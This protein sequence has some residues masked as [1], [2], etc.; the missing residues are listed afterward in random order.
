MALTELVMMPGEDYQAIC[1]AV[2]NKT[3]TTSLLCSGEVAP[4]IEAIVTEGTDTSDATATAEDLP[5]GVTAYVKG[6][7]ITGMVESRGMNFSANMWEG[8]LYL[9][10]SFEDGEL[11]TKITF[12]FDH[13][14]RRE[15][16]TLTLHTPGDHFGDA[17]AADVAKG[18]TFTSASGLKITGNYEGEDDMKKIRGAIITATGD[19]TVI[20]ATGESTAGGY[21]KL[22]A[23]QYAMTYENVAHGGATVASGIVDEDGATRFSICDSIESMRSDA[24]IILISGG[25]NDQAMITKGYED[26][27]TLTEGFSRQLN[28]STFYGGL[29]YLLRQAVYKW[30][31]KTILFIIPHRMTGTLD[32]RT[33]ILE[34]CKKYGVPVVDL[35]EFTPDFYNLKEFK[36]QYTANGDGWHA[37]EEGYLRFYVPPILS[38]IQRYFRGR[39]ETVTLTD[40][41][42]PTVISVNTATSTAET[43]TPNLAGF[44]RENGT[45]S[46]SANYLRTDYIPLDGKTTMEYNVFVMATSGMAT[47]AVFDESRRWLASSGDVNV[48]DYYHESVT[49]DPK[50]YGYKH[51][52]KS[53]AEL[54]ETHPTAAYVVVSTQVTP[55]YE[56]IYD[57][58]GNN[59]G[60]GSEDAYI[61]LTS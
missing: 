59:I 49:G 35:M 47:W 39:G 2:R 61:T 24:D 40:D 55:E 60:W 26:L 19:S 37:N 57:A 1:D 45:I 16:H 52:T 43:Y 5:K 7:K 53:I 51:G 46:T 27:G 32:F 34:T 29:E 23:D 48:E 9:G 4:A 31:N 41:K 56:T 14:F 6:K 12:P 44:I 13:L 8:G 25:V 36:V 58:D 33:A 50:K 38:G 42:M 3:G 30:S 15:E 17:T 20:A 18:K 22:I 28:K 10:D 54:R 21:V 11:V